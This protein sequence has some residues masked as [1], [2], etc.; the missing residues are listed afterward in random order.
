VKVTSRIE[1]S[2]IFKKGGLAKIRII[3]STPQ[4]RGE[5]RR[6]LTPKIIR[7]LFENPSTVETT[8]QIEKGK[9]DD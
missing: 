5:L 3:S 7:S 4:L 2:V 6:L 8:R 1:R 9:P